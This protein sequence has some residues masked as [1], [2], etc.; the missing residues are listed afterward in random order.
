MITRPDPKGPITA[1]CD[2]CLS[3]TVS[4]GKTEMATAVVKM[5][6]AGWT[7]TYGGSGH[8][9]LHFCEECER[10]RDGAGVM[11]APMSRI[12]GHSPI[13]VELFESV[14]ISPPAHQQL[15]DM[16]DALHGH[17]YLLF[18]SAPCKGF[19]RPLK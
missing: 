17:G 1:R 19:A 9:W 11:P 12:V 16:V 7:V 2:M 4:T 8:G 15:A 13:A 3:E 18:E 10:F 14:P 5:R 6:G